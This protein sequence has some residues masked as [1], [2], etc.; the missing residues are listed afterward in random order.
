MIQGTCS[1][2]LSGRV[3]LFSQKHSGAGAGDRGA[4]REKGDICLVHSKLRV[5]QNK[6]AWHLTYAFHSLTFVKAQSFHEG[7]TNI[8]FRIVWNCNWNDDVW[9]RWLIQYKLSSCKKHGKSSCH[10]SWKD[11]LWYFRWPVVWGFFYANAVLYLEGRVSSERSLLC[12]QSLLLWR[13]F[14]FSLFLGE[15]GFCA[16]GCFGFGS[17]PSISAHSS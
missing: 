1:S 12:F 8:I 3:I 16:L 9:W 4:G 6:G 5:R 11:L 17:K 14:P 7:C 15:L 10:Y 13:L 2:L